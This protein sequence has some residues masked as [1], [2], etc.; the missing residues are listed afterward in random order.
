MFEYCGIKDVFIGVWKNKKSF[1][2][3]IMI[4]VLVFCGVNYA[5]AQNT[6]KEITYTST[7][8]YVFESVMDEKGENSIVKYSGGQ[9][10]IVYKSLIESEATREYIVN[11]LKEK[12]ESVSTSEISNYILCSIT[13]D[14]FVLNITVTAPTSN[15]VIKIFDALKEYFDIYQKELYNQGV[16]SY[17]ITGISEIQELSSIMEFDLIKSMLSGIVV[18]TFLGGFIIGGYCLAIPKINRKDDF[19]RLGICVI[20]NF[21]IEGE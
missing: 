9:I 2:S 8:Q 21:R 14:G 5:K 19:E 3:I 4:S 7:G 16:D 18:G 15:L 13:G 12:G 20:G 6:V 11:Y 10:A 1:L 17:S